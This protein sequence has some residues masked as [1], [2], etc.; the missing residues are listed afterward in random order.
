MV[1]KANM[2]LHTLLALTMVMM[3]S[4][5]IIGNALADTEK[6]KEHYNSGIQEAQAGNTDAAIVAYKAA[7]ATDADYVDAYINLGAIYFQQKD[8]QKALETY[9]A[10]TEK[11]PQN[12]AALTNLGR[13][14]LKLKKYE[15]AE[16]SFKTVIE[17]DSTNTDLYKELGKTYFYKKD[18]AKLIETLTKYHNK[19]GGDHLSHYM[20][21]KG[22]QKTDKPTNAVA[23]FKKSIELKSD[24]YNSHFALGQVYL[25]QEKFKSA[26]S[27][28][29]AALKAN[30]KKYLASY[31]YAVA[32]ESSNPENYTRS[33]QVWEDFIKLAKKNP[34]AKTSVANAQ[35]HVKE[36]MEAAEQA[37][38]Q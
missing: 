1:M 16:T 9:S 7:I 3:S 19:G 35:Q 31:N 4:V 26:A 17:I 23:G 24:Y 27:A 37:D 8:Y 20:L 25:G 33:I 5:L 36:L 34:K 30:P 10:A 11:A 18:Y 13:V 22:Y 12:S 15:E 21:G 2:K 32:V 14:Q 38:L 29:K 6:A 28:F